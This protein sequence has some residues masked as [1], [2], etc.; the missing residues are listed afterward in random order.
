MTT[1]LITGCSSGYGLEIA[2]H[3]HSQGWTVVATMR[4][5]RADLFSAS[6]RIRVLPLDITDPASI[7]AAIEA[8]G[9]IDALVNNAGI[10]A[11]GAFEA[12]PMAYVRKIFETN[13]FGTMAMT[14]AAIPP[15]EDEA[16]PMSANPWADF[17]TGGV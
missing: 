5:P 4:K 15:L 12:T 6:D 8:A 3:F 16:N 9:P 1:I 11:F 2:R 7:A 10:G 17:N 13:T 14:Q